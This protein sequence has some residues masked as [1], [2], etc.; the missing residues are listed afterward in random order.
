VFLRLTACALAALT[1]AACGGHG[2]RQTAGDDRAVAT[3][4]ARAVFLGDRAGARSL[5]L[6][7]HETAIDFLVSRATKR[8]RHQRVAIADGAS[9]GERWT[10]RYAGTRS[11]SDG[12]F[13]REQGTLLVVLAASPAGARVRY[14]AFVNVNA[15]YSTHH[16]GQLLPS[17][18]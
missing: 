5:L 13:E 8:W 2:Q 4:F 12:R 11:F 10:F 18:R 1:L 9:S 6:H 3:R 16:D 14:F 7:E 15:R 17:K